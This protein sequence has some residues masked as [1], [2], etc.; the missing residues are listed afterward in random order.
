M[1]NGNGLAIKD[2]DIGGIIVTVHKLTENHQYIRKI[3]RRVYFWK[4]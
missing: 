2:L 1:V 3:K 4:F